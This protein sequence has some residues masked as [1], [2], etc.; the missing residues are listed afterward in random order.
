MIGWWRW[1]V[2]DKTVKNHVSSTRAKLNLQRRALA[3]AFVARH[4]LRGA[5]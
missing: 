1:A 2:K 3:A 5:E 4:R